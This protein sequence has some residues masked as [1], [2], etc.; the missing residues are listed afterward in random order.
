MEEERNILQAWQQSAEPW[1]ATVDAGEIASRALA[2]N[3]AIVSA[4]LA[5]KPERVLDAGCGEGWLSRALASEGLD[6]VGIDGVPELV[7]RARELGGGAFYA[8]SYED[9]ITGPAPDLGTFDVIAFNFSL[10][11]K[12]LTERLLP[13]LNAYLKPGGRLIVQTLHPGH[14]L[15]QK[16]DAQGWVEED[17]SAMQRDY[18]V[19]Y[20][21]HFKSLAE[22]RVLFRAAGYRVVAEQSVAH[23][24][25]GA[26]LSLVLTAVCSA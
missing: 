26:E 13:K 10:F 5:S 9:L 1:I 6:A 3:A 15:S 4:I 7:E 11:G 19:S 8:Y 12:T 20:R 17:W 23:P 21:W 14:E 2:T 16:R 25:T 24:D 22:W 18:P